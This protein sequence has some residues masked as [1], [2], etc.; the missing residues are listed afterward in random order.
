LNRSVC[1]NVL[2]RV[3][4]LKLPT[5]KVK[6]TVVILTG[7][8]LVCFKLAGKNIALTKF[9]HQRKT[10]LQFYS[11]LFFK[12]NIG[13]AKNHM[14]TELQAIKLIKRIMKRSFK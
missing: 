1:F 5:M 3:A 13:I 11:T 6:I 12:H 4:N 2:A 9:L 10:Q 7:T 8:R 14:S